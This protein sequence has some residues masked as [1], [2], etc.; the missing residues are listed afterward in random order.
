MVTSDMKEMDCVEV[1]VEKKK[2]TNE[3]VHKGMQGWICLD[4]CSDGYWLVNFP[5]YGDKPNIA[6]IGIHQD[7]MV[8]ISKMDARV[9]ERIKAEHE[10][11]R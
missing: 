7:D 1:I 9:N 10:E 8:V 3:G 6:T 11:K 4:D 2:Y 5:Q